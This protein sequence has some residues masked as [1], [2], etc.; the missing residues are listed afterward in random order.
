VAKEAIVYECENPACTLG[1]L[2]QA[3]RFTGGITAAQAT[4]L[5]GDP[6][7]KHGPGVCPNCGQAAK[8]VS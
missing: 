2:H 8:K 3:G 1:T 7:A 5:T 6:E 4:A